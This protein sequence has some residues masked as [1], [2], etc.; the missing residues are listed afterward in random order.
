MWYTDEELK[1]Q[2]HAQIDRLENRREALIANLAKLRLEFIQEF[3]TDFRLLVHLNCLT[4]VAVALLV[5][6]SVLR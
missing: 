4:C 6:D 5:L 2:L 3:E 1:E